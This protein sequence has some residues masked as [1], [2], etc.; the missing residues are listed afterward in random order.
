MNVDARCSTYLS[1]YVDEM[2][3]HG[4]KG[5]SEA[6]VDVVL[7]K[8][9]IIFRYLRDKDVFENVYKTHLQKRL[10]DARSLS[11]EVERSMLTKLKVRITRGMLIASLST[12][13]DCCGGGGHGCQA[14]CGFQ[15]TSK[16]EG[17]FADLA[18]SRD[19][20]ALYRKVARSRLCSACQ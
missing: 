18:N 14:E 8:V 20:L 15:F 11:D 4:F 3:K 17:M 13:C 5:V 9:V 12:R 6:D 19:T 10:L 7:D 1:L 16:M 2:M